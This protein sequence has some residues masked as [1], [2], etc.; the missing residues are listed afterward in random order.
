MFAWQLSKIEDAMRRDSAAPLR[1]PWFP[2]KVPACLPG[3]T[4]GVDWGDWLVALLVGR[5]V[6]AWLVFGV[7]GV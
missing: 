3:G 5:R 1:A 6:V 4:R 2:R 7:E